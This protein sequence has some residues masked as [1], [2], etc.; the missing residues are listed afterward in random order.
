YVNADI[1]LLSDFARAFEK[2]RRRLSKF[3]MVS[4]RINIHI[5]EALTFEAG[6][7]SRMK[8][9]RNSDGVAGD[10]KFIDVFVFPKGMYAHVPDFAIGRLW[11]DSWLLKAVWE[12]MS[13]VVYWSLVCR[14]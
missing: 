5:P 10:H 12:Q 4:R 6:W 2:V 1:V 3:L 14:V 7:E 11:V 9:R 13:E 8:T